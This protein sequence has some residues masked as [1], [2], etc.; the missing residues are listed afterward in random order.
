M[1]GPHYGEWWN[2]RPA[3]A[4]TRL[5]IA[6]VSLLLVLAWGV[7]AG[8]SGSRLRAALFEA[9]ERGDADAVRVLLARG[10][11]A[12]AQH[13]DGTALLHWAQEHGHRELAMLLVREGADVNAVDRNVVAALHRAASRGDAE[14]VSLLLEAGAEP[15]A[16]S[17]RHGAPLHWAAQ[18]GS[19]AIVRALLDAGAPVDPPMSGCT[20]RCTWRCC[21]R[22]AGSP[23]CCARAVPTPTRDSRETARCCT[24]PRPRDGAMSP[25]WSS[26]SAP[27]S[28]RRT[29]RAILRCITRRYEAMSNFRRC[30]SSMGP[31]VSAPTPGFLVTPLHYAARGGH[32]ETIRLLLAHGA[33]ANAPSRFYGT[34][35]HWAAGRGQ[36]E[37]VGLLI[38]QGARATALDD[39]RATSLERARQRGHTEVAMLLAA[40]TPA[41]EPFGTPAAAPRESA[42]WRAA[43]TY[44]PGEPCF[45]R[46]LHRRRSHSR[47]V[48]PGC[49]RCPTPTTWGWGRA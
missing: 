7:Y 25:R 47:R 31:G 3:L 8:L 33:D 40:I 22:I 39:H 17:R 42:G 30:S 11:S 15:G 32:L 16:M 41:V 46:P 36:R 14:L 2:E 24:G 23:S 29:A 38:A 12:S 43:E 18:A 35:L 6:L 28:A 48:P 13:A 37:T 9:T 49:S 21:A 44:A 26:R 1:I 10:G 4:R 20:R 45:S 19:A 34:P 5:A 27:M